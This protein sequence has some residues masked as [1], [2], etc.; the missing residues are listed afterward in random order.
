MSTPEPVDTQ[1]WHKRFAAQANNRAWD[2]S[3][4]S[5]TPDEDRE[6]LDAAHSAAWHWG[7]I[8][9]ELHRM[10]ATMLLAEVHAQLGYGA[11]AFQFAQDMHAY[12]MAHDTPDWEIA[13]AHAIYA[14]AA[15]VAG[16]S[17][18]HRRAYE[19]A[20]LA[21]DAIADVQ[22]RAIVQKTFEQIPPP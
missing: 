2:L 7:Q 22:D 3:T 21:V 4:V 10:R 5:R 9:T 15:C 11:S 13:F 20:K 8:G 12:F 16:A 6:M 18:I 14:H 1:A 19:S 17:A